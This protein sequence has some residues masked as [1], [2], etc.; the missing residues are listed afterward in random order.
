M[1]VASEALSALRTVQAFNAQPQEQ[2]RFHTRVEAVLSLAKKEAV[3][4]GI[5]FGS[6]GWSGNVTLLALLGY[7]KLFRWLS[8]NVGWADLL[9]RWYTGFARSDISGG[10]DQSPSLHGIRRHWPTNAHVR[11]PFF[12]PYFAPANPK[13]QFLL[14]ANPI[15]HVPHSR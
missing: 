14:R 13:P 6:T 11:P 12:L 1:K 10:L 7:G 2:E 5:F 9:G 3:A 4:S 8:G 15:P